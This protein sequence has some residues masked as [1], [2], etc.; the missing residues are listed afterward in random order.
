MPTAQPAGTVEV[1]GQTFSTTVLPDVFDA[2]DL[3]YRPVLSPLPPVLDARP[4]DHPVLTQEGSSCTGHAVAAMINTVLAS[5]PNPI[6]VSPYMLYRMARRYDEYDGED[7]AGSS[8]RGALKGWYYHGVLPE[9]D[10]PSLHADVDLDLDPVLARRA[11]RHP[12]GAFYRVNA[13]RLDDL[14]SAINE[15]HAVAASAQVH[16]GWLEPVRV[17][18][19][20]GSTLHVITRTA[21]ARPLGGHA[22]ALVGYNDVGFLVQNSWGTGWGA[23]GFA[24]LPYE[25]WLGSAFDAWVARPGVPSAVD[26]HR[27]TRVVSTTSGGVGAGPGPDLERLKDHV[28]NLGNEGKLST[29]GRFVSTP[30]QLDR[31]FTTMAGTHQAWRAAAAG[32]QAPVRRVVFYAHGGLTSEGAGLTVAQAQLNW[33]LNNG[34]YP[35][36]FAW[37]SG[38]VETLLDQL[39]DLTSGRL[40]FGG[41]GFDLV[42]QADRLVESLARGRL[43]WMWSQMKENAAAASRPLP[44]PVAWPTDGTQPDPGLAGL[45]GASLVATRLQAYLA[46]AGEPVEVHLA[47]HSAGAIF[48]AN[49]LDRLAALNIP[50]ASV[51]WLAPALRVDAFENLVLPRLRSGQLGRVTVFGLSDARELDDV[52]GNGN[53]TIYQKSLLFLV[54][55]GLEDV[56]ET[57]LL[58][59]QRHVLENPHLSL[60]RASNA[61]FSWSPTDSPAFL[62]CGATSHSGMDED[63]PAMTA[64]LLGILG[65]QQGNAATT[66]RP[67]SAL[68]VPTSAVPAASGTP[69]TVGSPNGQAARG[70]DGTA[71]TVAVE[72]A[73]SVP[74]TRSGEP[75]KPSLKTVTD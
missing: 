61:A 59:L 16:S 1:S 11:L 7:D 4:A 19:E 56:R 75:Q 14:Q 64:M 6:R 62:R 32:T 3:E 46:T 23:S 70:A 2:R 67:F 71:P 38:P 25:D 55:R 42:E 13:F 37:Q 17:P 40:P 51:T 26:P 50:V 45:P 58:G 53:L 66:F 60:W 10:W 57:R 52:V 49:L 24:T 22:F 21:D 9:Q 39:S 36:T 35:V 8:L 69:P 28:V 41:L 29:N 12:L 15:L 34:V 33:W 27:S 30:A 72:E 54:S 65:A 5:Q 44:G 31:I 73:G 18:G 43:G 63:V 47:G 20:D 48:T 68:E 74:V